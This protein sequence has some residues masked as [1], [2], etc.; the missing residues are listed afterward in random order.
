VDELISSETIDEFRKSVEQTMVAFEAHFGM[1]PTALVMCPSDAEIWI[2]ARKRGLSL[3]EGMAI[4]VN[5][6]A[7]ASGL[8][9]DLAVARAGK[10]VLH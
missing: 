4:S 8:R 1:K 9:H 2:E 7:D 5:P 10:H 3:F 6:L